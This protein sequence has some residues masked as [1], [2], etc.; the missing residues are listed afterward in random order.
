MVFPQ[1]AGLVAGRG[2]QDV[3]P[4]LEV[5]DGRAG[6]T[7]LV[8]SDHVLPGGGDHDPPGAVEIAVDRVTVLSQDEHKPVNSEQWD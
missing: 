3:L 4:G 7:E 6:Q 8:P 1:G 2:G 5:P